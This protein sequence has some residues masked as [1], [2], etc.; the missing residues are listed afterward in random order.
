MLLMT[1]KDFN[2]IELDLYKNENLIY[3]GMS[4]DIP[5]EYKDKQIKI[6]GID[7]KKLIIKLINDNKEAD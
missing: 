4:E 5:E 3:T 1:I 7:G 6:D 2:L